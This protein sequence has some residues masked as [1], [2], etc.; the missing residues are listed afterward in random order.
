M[1]KNV[2]IFASYNEAVNLKILLEKFANLFNPSIDAVI[3]S[4][5]TGKPGN[6]SID[7]ILLQYLG[8]YNFR[9]LASLSE[10]KSGRGSAIRRG[11]ILG[12]K[13]FPEADYFYEVDSDGSHRMEDLLRLRDFPESDF[14]I[15][16]R[17]LPDSKIVGWTF[18][19]RILSRFLNYWIPRVLKISSTD[20][21]NGMRRYSVKAVSVVCSSKPLNA[22]FIQL[23]ETAK[24]LKAKHIQPEEVPIVFS[25]R[26]SGESSVGIGEITRSLIGLLK[27]ILGQWGESRKSN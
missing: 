12:I 13:S 9:F 10:T 23:T 17:Y 8:P 24:I 6:E 4:D 19:R 16:S 27:M 5:D 7:Q 11:L 1:I 18:T 14:V 25:D 3:I 20:L 26:I 21:T 15:G 2:Y 22:G